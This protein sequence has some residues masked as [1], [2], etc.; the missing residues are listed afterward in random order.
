M[1]VASLDLRARAIAARIVI[2]TSEGISPMYLGPFSSLDL[3]LN[4]PLELNVTA[5]AAG[6]TMAAIVKR[7]LLVSA[8]CQHLSQT[9]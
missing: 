2:F 9:L 7:Y 6:E 1:G 8:R 5:D 3:P 4:A